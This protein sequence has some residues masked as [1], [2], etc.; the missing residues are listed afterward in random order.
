MFQ[1]GYG[2]GGRFFH[3]QG[4]EAREQLARQIGARQRGHGFRQGIFLDHA[5]AAALPLGDERDA[6]AHQHQR[7]AGHA[8]K[9][10]FFGRRHEKPPSPVS[11]THLDVYKR[12]HWEG[13]VLPGRS[14]GY[15]PDMLDA[16]LARG[17]A[18]WRVL[19]G[20][21]TLLRFL[22]PEAIDW[23]ALPAGFD[24]PALSEEERA[25]LALLSRRGASFASALGPNALPA[26]MRLAAKLSLI[27][28]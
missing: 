12:Q 6:P 3:A 22:S 11:Y 18:V 27:H 7:V 9:G 28:I 5:Q 4:V 25:M 17:E 20:E 15:R 24:D 16:L 26:L 21:P 13:A 1:R 10:G 2:A 19:P 14:L 23:N 8:H